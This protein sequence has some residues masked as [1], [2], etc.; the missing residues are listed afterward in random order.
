MNS[1]CCRMIN[2][3]TGMALLCGMTIYVSPAGS[4]LDYSEYMYWLGNQATP[5]L[6][7]DVD[8]SG[9]YAFI[10]DG[11]AGALQILDITDPTEMFIVGSLDTPGYS[12]GI[13]VRGD[14][15]YL[16][17]GESGLI[18]IDITDPYNPLLMGILE[19]PGE[20]TAV[21][22]DGD[23]AYLA[24]G[25]MGLQVVDIANPALPTIIGNLNTSGTAHDVVLDQGHVFLAN[26][27]AG[28]MII[29]VAD[30][31]DPV[32]IGSLD[33]PG[34]ARGVAVTGTIT[35]IADGAEGLH[36]I[37][38]THLNTPVQISSV[39]SSDDALKVALRG[40]T[41]FVTN[42]SNGFFAVDISDPLHPEVTGGLNTP[43]WTDAIVI[44]DDL[45]YLASHQ[46][47]LTVVS[48]STPFSAP[49]ISEIEN[50]LSG[51][52]VEVKG[53][54]AYVIGWW[55]SFGLLQIFDVT[56]PA[57]PLLV[58]SL[59]T[60]RYPMEIAVHGDLA[61]VAN[62]FSGLL[63]VDISNPASP[64]VVGKVDTDH[65][66]RDVCFFEGY[67]YM[68]M[69]DSA[70]GLYVIDVRNPA[71]PKI[72]HTLEFLDEP[73]DLVVSGHHLCV[74]DGH[75]GLLVLDIS[76]P[77]LPILAGTLDT[78]Y[79][80]NGIAASGPLVY[81]EE[82]VGFDDSGILHIID[83]AN[84]ASPLILA[85]VGC[86]RSGYDVEV[87]AGFVYIVDYYSSLTILD[88]RDPINPYPIGALFSSDAQRAVSI[89][90]DHIYL[91]TVDHALLVAERP[92]A[93]A[94]PQIHRVADV[95]NDQGGQ[96]RMSWYRSGYD[97]I[98]GDPRITGYSIWRRIDY[99][100]S[101]GLSLGGNKISQESRTYPPGDWEFLTTVPARGEEEYHAIIPTLCDSTDSGIC[102]TT[103]FVSALTVDPLIFFDSEA[104]AGY[105]VDN[106]APAIPA[107]FHRGEGSLLAW[108]DSLEPDF[109]YFTVYGSETAGL[110]LSA[111]VITYTTETTLDIG[112]E[113]HRFFHLTATDFSGNESDA[114]TLDILTGVR[115]SIP[116][117][118]ALHNCAP[119]PF[120][121]R[122][123]L[124][125]DLP[126]PT[127][128]KLVIYGLD[129][130]RVKI[131]VHGL[132]SSG[133]HA[134]EWLGRD[135]KG[136]EVASGVYMYCLTAGPY[137]E[138]RRM[139]LVK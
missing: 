59:E 12:K 75:E 34:E 1:Q 106:L 13:T 94:S 107:G 137:T 18:L 67:A 73:I 124:Q 53:D 6:A 38:I 20:T 112:G 122:T 31:Q 120:N 84:P 134:V 3:A 119:N 132:M 66:A 95:P 65:A 52:S 131:L 14:M 136:A 116:P 108:D 77:S 92:L 82:N 78:E 83:I 98:D 68:T 29:D 21:T 40:K 47:G 130:K 87:V 11:D 60:P 70:F 117:S 76:D 58:S 97:M 118:Y 7:L 63:V 32:V 35:M 56:D 45:I 25:P 16:C 62:D 102:Y 50:G 123:R 23:L 41:A 26:G 88:A 36:V 126:E 113:P 114:A 105:S 121:P 85:T 125:F 72:V 44:S 5:G 89:A 133:T 101:Q 24:D 55:G 99:W 19:T 48:A 127:H 28:L 90:G 104:A 27:E 22:I 115:S 96:V 71:E 10:A 103:L 100:K 135:E 69:E 111:V 61:Y 39:P 79:W 129:G 93:G 86:P 43:G 8:I 64:A 74:A 49:I 37:D 54:F 17:D 128:V 46:S 57:T 81:L 42:H 138:T 2:I 91:G 110:D 15:A 33:T 109:E 4:S 51:R 139:V 80:A 9:N 30:P